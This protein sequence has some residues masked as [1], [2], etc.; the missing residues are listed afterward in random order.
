PYYT[1][2]KDI[3]DV[4]VKN[5]IKPAK[6]PMHSEVELL[7]KNGG[8]KKFKKD[9]HYHFDISGLP[10]MQVYLT[11]K[12]NHYFDEYHPFAEPYHK[13]GRPFVMPALFFLTPFEEFEGRVGGWITNTGDLICIF[14]MQFGL[15]CEEV[16]ALMEE[17]FGQPVGPNLNAWSD[18]YGL[19][20]EVFVVDWT[21]TTSPVK[22]LRWFLDAE[23]F[24]E[25]LA[26]VPELGD[27]LVLAAP[28][29]F[30]QL[31]GK[32]HPWATGFPFWLKE[33]LSN[34]EAKAL[35][36]QFASYQF[37]ETIQHNT[38]YK[39]QTTVIFDTPYLGMEN[40]YDYR[41]HK[42]LKETF[43]M[44]EEE[45]S[46]PFY[47][48]EPGSR[49]FPIDANTYMTHKMGAGTQHMLQRI[50]ARREAM[51]LYDYLTKIDP[52]YKLDDADYA[53]AVKAYLKAADAAIEWRHK[54]AYD[55]ALKGLGYLDKY[56]T[57][58]GEPDWLFTDWDTDIKFSPQT[59]GLQIPAEQLDKDLKKIGGE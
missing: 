59:T 11:D 42:D 9:W 8:W 54:E 18:A 30:D 24:E 49:D 2:P 3:R 35:T 55:E 6:Y 20:W 12:L 7:G 32:F 17:K 23:P 31:F 16:H 22:T 52:T 44:T 1:P 27:L 10:G 26:A 48:T 38:G 43:K 19:W 56:Y 4:L 53:E 58:K 37:A 57:S 47:S 28:L 46:M 36:R 5:L 21:Y 34:P 33:S 13:Y 50:F 40:G 45:K 25:M 15:T 14:A 29:L 41:K 51:A 39:H